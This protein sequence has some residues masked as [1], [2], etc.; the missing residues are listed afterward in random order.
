VDDGFIDG[1]V[2]RTTTAFGGQVAIAPRIFLRE[3]VDVMDRV[4][5]H[6]D[7]DPARDYA[8]TVADDDLTPEELAAARAQPPDADAPAAPHRL[9]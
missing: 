8:F 4:D 6:P 1:L 7:Y 5:L 2:A 9:S 3:L